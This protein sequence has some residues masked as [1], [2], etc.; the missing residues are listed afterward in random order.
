MTDISMPTTMRAPHFKGGGQ[1]DFIE[2]SGTGHGHGQ[3]LL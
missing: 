3:L 1:I 2:K